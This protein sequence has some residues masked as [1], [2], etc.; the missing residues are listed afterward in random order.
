MRGLITRLR[1]RRRDRR[2][3]RDLEQRYRAQIDA[4]NE[5]AAR[6]SDTA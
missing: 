4:R 6:M 1:G 2:L 5:A 3:A